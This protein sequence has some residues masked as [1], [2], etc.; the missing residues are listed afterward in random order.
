MFNNV[1]IYSKSNCLYCDKAKNY[2]TQ[3]NISYVEHNVEVPEVFDTLMNRNPNAR[4]M[5]QIFIDN[6]LIGGYT[7]LEDWLQNNK[8]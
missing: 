1:E 2:F 3:N 7:D 5:P 6:E 4:T 8:D